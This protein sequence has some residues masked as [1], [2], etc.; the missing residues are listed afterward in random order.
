MAKVS[1]SEGARLA[2]ISRTHLYKR[3]IHPGKITVETAGDG[4]R[5][6]DT[7][8][9]LR[10]FGTLDGNTESSSR[11][12]HREQELTPVGNSEISLLQAELDAV[13]EML[14]VREGQLADA[15]RRE[16]EAAERE[17][18]LQGQLSA[19]TRLLEDKRPAATPPESSRR[20]WWPFGRKR[21][22]GAA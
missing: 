22:A 11:I 14:K 16:G 6:I 13:R 3:Y 5:Q 9:L 7:A 19:Q 8:E 2:G 15:A 12:R 21:E 17:K 1:I 4:T 10:V 20:R 18:W